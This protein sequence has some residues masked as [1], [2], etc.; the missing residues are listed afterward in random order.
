MWTG[1]Y[2]TDPR[3]VPEARKMEVISYERDAELASAGAGVMHSR[4]SSSPR[5]STYR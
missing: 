3:L 1:V 4:R 5:N 2:T